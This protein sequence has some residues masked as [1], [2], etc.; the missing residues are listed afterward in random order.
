[1]RE[2]GSGTR[3]SMEALLIKQGFNPKTLSICAT[4]GSSEAVKE[5]IKSNLGVSIISIHAVQEELENG[6]LKEIAIDNINM[7][8]LFYIVTPTRRTLPYKYQE[9]LKKL[10][11]SSITL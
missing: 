4:L 6:Q 5:A 1:M 7:K 2:E 3:K 9:L 8:R 10:I 11:N